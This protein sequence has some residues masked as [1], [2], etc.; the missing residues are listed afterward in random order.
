M[1]GLLGAGHGPLRAAVRVLAEA[2]R[3]ELS[4]PFAALRSFVAVEALR[5]GADQVFAAIAREQSY[6]LGEAIDYL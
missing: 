5:H 3:A 2:L 6:V 1:Q 4:Y